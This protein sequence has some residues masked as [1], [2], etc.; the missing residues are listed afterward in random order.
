MK[1]IYIICLSLCMFSCATL[2]QIEGA[3]G[4]SRSNA[5]AD[6]LDSMIIFYP[7]GIYK[8]IYSANRLAG[9][10]SG[11]DTIKREQWGSW[12]LIKGN[13]LELSSFV[14]PSNWE[15]IRIVEIENNTL[16]QTNVEIVPIDTVFSD[17]PRFIIGVKDENSLFYRMGKDSVVLIPNKI[18]GIRVI[19]TQMNGDYPFIALNP[20]FYK[21]VLH[22]FS[23]YQA[24]NSGAGLSYFHRYRVKVRRNRLYFKTVEYIKI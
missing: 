2:K 23:Q 3:Y 14:Q 13:V 22:V 17:Q 8:S 7:G 18:S 10:R 5:R 6:K 1:Y 24:P 16:K 19:G 11:G 9:I 12:K 20:G 4:E 21:I 15:G